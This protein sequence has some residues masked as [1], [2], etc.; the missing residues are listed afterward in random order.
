M[1]YISVYF[2]I[3]HTCKYQPLPI[4]KAR[5]CFSVLLSA[6]RASLARICCPL[7]RRGAGRRSCKELG[8]AGAVCAADLLSV[9]ISA[10]AVA[11][12]APF[13]LSCVIKPLAEAAEVGPGVWFA[14][15]I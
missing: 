1:V 4:I 9:S 15:N 12:G 3:N 11:P 13:P 14:E 5:V 2:G 6:P 10:L 7:A 8:A